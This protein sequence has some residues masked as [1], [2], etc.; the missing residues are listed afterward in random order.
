MSLFTYV[1]V[2]VLSGTGAT[3]RF[4]VDKIVSVRFGRDLPLG[5]FVVNISGAV[6]LGVVV[7]LSLP[8]DTALLAGTAAV[9]SYTTFSTWI[10][11]SHRFGED[12]AVRDLAANLAG[13]LVLG[14]AAVALGRLIGGQL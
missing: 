3:A 14:V 1:A 11:E 12:G 2:V 6:L 9:G 5:T 13:S 4:A 7:G 10:L 8:H